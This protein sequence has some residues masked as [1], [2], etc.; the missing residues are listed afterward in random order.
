[1]DENYISRS[2][3][4]AWVLWGSAAVLVAAIWV[5]AALDVSEGLGRA[6]AVTAIGFMAVAL[7]WQIRLFMQRLCA[8]VRTT[9]ALQ[10]SGADLHTIG[11][12]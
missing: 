3:I 7:A 8:L 11:R 5:L 12:N 2:T 6:V 4:V 9:S 1:M 10:R